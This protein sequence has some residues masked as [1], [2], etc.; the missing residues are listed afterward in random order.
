MVETLSRRRDR[1]HRFSLHMQPVVVVVGSVTTPTASYVVV[2]NI[3]WKL[4]TPLKAV[5]VDEILLG[6]KSIF[7]PVFLRVPGQ[8]SR[9]LCGVGTYAYNSLDVKL[10]TVF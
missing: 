8:I 2:D 6:P 4:A 10:S 1:L 9:C 3:T 7:S 5:D